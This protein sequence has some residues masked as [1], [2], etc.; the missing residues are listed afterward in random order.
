MKKSQELKRITLSMGTLSLALSAFILQSMFDIQAV[1]KDTI[2]RFPASLTVGADA[3]EP[4]STTVRKLP[5]DCNQSDRPSMEVRSQFLQLQF[6][7]CQERQPVE[8]INLTNG[9]QATLFKTSKDSLSDLIS[10]N[11]GDNEIQLRL[12]KSPIPLSLK[13]KATY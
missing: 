5:F 1:A 2:S 8:V 10:L 11:E 9:F 6:E 12:E 7:N 3:K 13:I 4:Q